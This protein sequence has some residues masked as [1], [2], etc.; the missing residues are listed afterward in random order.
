MTPEAFRRAFTHGLQA[1]AG[2]PL[3]AA[4]PRYDR[5]C[6]G[7]APPL[8]EGMAVQDGS[9]AGVA[10]RRVRPAGALPGEVVYVHGGGWT[11][12]SVASHQGIAASLAERLGREVVS[13]DYRLAPEAS[14]V[15]ALADCR[16]VI[17]ALTPRAAVGDSA[18]GRLVM[19]AAGTGEWRGPLGLIYPPVGHPTPDTLG[20]DAP[21]LSRKDVLA[22][23]AM[24]EDDLPEGDPALPP[25]ARLEVL[26]VEHDPLTAPL[27][28]AVAAWRAAG[29]EVGYRRAPGLWHG[30]LH[31]HAALPAMGEAWGDFC[32]A[33]AH[34]LS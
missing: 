9:V 15:E 1:L 24:V 23:W 11:L 18:G 4:R 22:L 20:P 10:V 27:E 2:L 31:A 17:E 14:Y 28:D 3:G 16:A 30:A 5:L 26:A 34:R 19:D 25:G 8:P 12:G 29:A 6:Q 7:F 32:T 33:L 13:V 21:L